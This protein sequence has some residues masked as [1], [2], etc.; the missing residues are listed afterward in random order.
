MVLFVGD[1][2]T[3]GQAEIVQTWSW[4]EQWDLWAGKAPVEH[5]QNTANFPALHLNFP[6]LLG[7]AELPGAV[8]A[9][10]ALGSSPGADQQ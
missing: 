3:A 1:T 5:R 4:S 10:P 8:G 7:Q 2:C 9:G 6:D